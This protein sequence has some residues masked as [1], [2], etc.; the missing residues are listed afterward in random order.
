MAKESVVYRSW[1]TTRL[2]ARSG[3]GLASR[4]LSPTLRGSRTKP[5]VVALTDQ[6][7]RWWDRWAIGGGHFESDGNDLLGQA[8]FIGRRFEEA[9]EEIRGQCRS[10]SRA[11][12]HG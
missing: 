2:F 5:S 12:R 3:E 11:G 6:G 4:Q 10:R 9:P 8:G 1:H 7:E